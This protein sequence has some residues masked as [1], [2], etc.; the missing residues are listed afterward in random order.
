MKGGQFK[1]KDFFEGLATLP[2]YKNQLA[3]CEKAIKVVYKEGIKKIKFDGLSEEEIQQLKK[4]QVHPI[5]ISASLHTQPIDDYI[6]KKVAKL[7]EK[8]KKVVES[9]N[10]SI[11]E[12]IK[13]CEIPKILKIL[14]D[15]KIKLTG[16]QEAEIKKAIQAVTS[17]DMEEFSKLLANDKFAEAFPAKYEIV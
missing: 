5:K 4:H 2:A 1:T 3:D 9:T 14:M 16:S 6:K 11:D 13:S 7:E 17:K 10:K 15:P 12:S 8:C